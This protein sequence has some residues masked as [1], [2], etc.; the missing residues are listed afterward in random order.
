[1]IGRCFLSLLQT[2][3]DVV[4]PFS[5]LNRFTLRCSDFAF[6]FIEKVFAYLNI[7]NGSNEI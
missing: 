7:I 1:M 2:P 5:V 6:K 3:N 4:R